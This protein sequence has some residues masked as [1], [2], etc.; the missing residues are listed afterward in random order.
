MANARSTSSI[1]VHIGKRIKVRRVMIGMSQ[2]KLGDK[3]GLTFQQVQK[4]EK[5]TNRVAAGRLQ[6]VAD[7][8]GVHIAFFYEGLSSRDPVGAE[9]GINALGDGS[10]VEKEV[11]QM[12]HAFNSIEDPKIRR[13]LLSMA[14][15]LSRMV[16]E[17]SL[18]HQA[19]PSVC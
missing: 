11:L 2:E 7:I 8:L 9:I 6:Q 5:G 3:L 13:A 4:Y 17:Q 16:P 12:L 10:S 18:E 15:A 1:D 19:R 14:Q